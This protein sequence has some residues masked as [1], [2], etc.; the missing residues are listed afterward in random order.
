M[1][2]LKHPFWEITHKS[3][4][5][6]TVTYFIAGILAMTL[7][8]YAEL[9]ADPN[10]AYPMRLLSDPIVYAAPLFQP[11]RGLL[12]GVIFYLLRDVLFRPRDGWLILWALLFIVGILNPFGPAPGSIEGMLFTTPSVWS[13]IMG[14]REIV[15]QALIL[16]LLLW[17]WVR[18]PDKRWLTWLMSTAFVLILIMSVMGVLVVT[19]R[20]PA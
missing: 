14:L 6:H 9:F 18:T 11:L 13:Q 1:P 7:F 20:F 19:G 12:F 5:T 2:E 10:N 15:F 4:V 17:Y 8:D 16:S 3:I